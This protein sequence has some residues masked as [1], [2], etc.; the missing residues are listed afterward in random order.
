MASPGPEQTFAMKCGGWIRRAKQQKARA[1]EMIETIRQMCDR[2]Q[3]MRKPP[4]FATVH[5]EAG[6]RSCHAISNAKQRAHEQSDGLSFVEASS[7][8]TMSGNYA[9]QTYLE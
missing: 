1:R 4:R 9:D 5:L 2:P 7:V 3:Q 6:S 8:Q